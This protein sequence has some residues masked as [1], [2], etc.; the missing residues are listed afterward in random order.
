[1]ND[2]YIKNLTKGLQYGL[3]QFLKDHPEF[4]LKQQANKNFGPKIYNKVHDF[5][6]TIAKT[7]VRNSDG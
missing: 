5:S 4:T 7:R 2:P 6:L 1:M 3:M